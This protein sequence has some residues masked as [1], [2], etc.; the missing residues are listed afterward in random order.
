MY[1]C[2]TSTCK[3]YPFVGKER[4]PRSRESTAL[5]WN[6]SCVGAPSWLCPRQGL[7]PFCSGQREVVH[8]RQMSN[9]AQKEAR[10]RLQILRRHNG[11]AVAQRL[12]GKNCHTD[13]PSSMQTD[14]PSL[15]FRSNHHLPKQ[16]D[17]YVEAV[18][19]GGLR[20]LSEM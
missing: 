6:C 9:R 14:V 10:I 4:P 11:R 13:S 7:H 3:I 19:L 12:G 17:M 16:A 2:C 1:A 5:R 8:H 20:R 18:V 15:G